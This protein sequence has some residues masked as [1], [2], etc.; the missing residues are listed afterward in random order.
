MPT[1]T[2]QIIQQLSNGGLAQLG[3]TLGIDQ[4]TAAKALSAAAPLLVAALAR[5]A[6]KPAGAQD[7]HQALAE[8][9][10]GSILANLPGLL[11]D[12]KAGDGAGILTH[13]LGD[14]R[15]PVEHGLAQD[16]GVSANAMS[17]LLELAAPVVLGMLG[18]QQRQQG[19]DSSG[20]A[21]LIGSEAQAEQNANPQLMQTLTGLLDTNDDGGIM[22]DISSMAGKL[23][24]R[25]KQ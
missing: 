11:N 2:E 13:V 10:D 18:Q 3:Q 7:L 5:N 22:D 23:F 24:K 20:L 25:R 15:G 1:M 14:K 6:A 17:G 9:H 4:Q 12:P 21:N 19:L 16:A 8:D